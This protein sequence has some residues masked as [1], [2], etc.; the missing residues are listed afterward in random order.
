MSSPWVGKPPVSPHCPP[1]SPHYARAQSA[2]RTA[3]QVQRTVGELLFYRTPSKPIFYQQ[4]TLFYI[5]FGKKMCFSLN[6]A[7]TENTVE[8][9][10]RQRKCYGKRRWLHQPFFRA[11]FS[12]ERKTDH[13]E[14]S[15]SWRGD[16]FQRDVFGSNKVLSLT[17]R[18][19][20]DSV[21]SIT[22]RISRHF[23]LAS[24]QPSCSS[25]KPHPLRLEIQV[26]NL[27]RCFMG[28]VGSTHNLLGKMLPNSNTIRAWKDLVSLLNP[29]LPLV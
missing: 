29:R 22:Q 23:C 17:L 1:F 13:Q 11:I 27:L 26:G 6:T 19:G 8:M 16:G 10:I 5:H 7:N 3:L 12:L 4:T 28:E 25:E 2:E 15:A 21:A 24:W 9:G 18:S 14:D 20:G